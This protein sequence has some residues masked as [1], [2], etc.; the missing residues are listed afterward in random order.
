MTIEEIN[1]FC[2]NS[3]IRHLNIEFLEYTDSF[4]KARMP[5]NHTTLQPMGV[6]HGGASLALAETVA[7]GGSVFQTD[8]DK[9]DVFGLQV[10]AS[11]I[12]TVSQG[13]V[14]AEANCIHKG[15]KTHVWDVRITDEENKLVSA[16]R[17]T[18]IIVEKS[19]VQEGKENLK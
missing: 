18:N 14:F 13:Y 16:V 17:V 2:E 10:S 4:V 5:V 6:L 8:P 12:S 9:F 1:N 11:H 3:L 7:S 19:N 15:K